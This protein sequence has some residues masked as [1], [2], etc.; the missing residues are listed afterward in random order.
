MRFDRSSFRLRADK[1]GIASAVRLAERMAASDK[2]DRL[3]V[4]HAHPLERLADV[5]AACERIG[6]A[7]RTFRIYI[8]QTHLNSGKRIVQLAVAFVPFVS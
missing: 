5:A 4:R 7:V 1:R 3:L 8:D 6:I 2:R